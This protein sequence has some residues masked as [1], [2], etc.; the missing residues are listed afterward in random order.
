[1][2]PTARL[3]ICILAAAAIAG[4]ALT[5][6]APSWD[7]VYAKAKGACDVRFFGARGATVDRFL[8]TGRDWREVPRKHRRVEAEQIPALAQQLCQHRPRALFVQARCLSTAGRW[9]SIDHTEANLC[10]E[11]P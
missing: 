11:A 3:A 6:R 2:T 5:Q 10:P 1:M 4:S 8:L 9:A 7:P